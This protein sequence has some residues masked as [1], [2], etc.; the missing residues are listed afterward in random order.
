MKAM[1]LKL[2]LV[3]GLMKT[4]QSHVLVNPLPSSAAQVELEVS[5]LYNARPYPHEGTHTTGCFNQVEKYGD[6][7]VVPTRLRRIADELWGGQLPSDIRILDAGTGTGEDCVAFVQELSALFPTTGGGKPAWKVVCLDLSEAS[8]AAT[9]RRLE[10]WRVAER[11]TLVQGS[12]LDE[13][14]MQSLGTFDFILAEG[15]I[16]T[17]KTPVDGVHALARLR[18]SKTSVMSIFLY[19][20]HGRTGVTEVQRAFRILQDARGIT[21]VA[22][23]SASEIDLLRT[24][25][26]SLPFHSLFRAQ[27]R[28]EGG[29]GAQEFLPHDESDEELA[30]MFL[31]P[32]EHQYTAA[33]VRAMAGE[34]GVALISWLQPAL[35]YPGCAFGHLWKYGRDASDERLAGAMQGLTEGQWENLTET[36]W[37]AHMHSLS[38][39]FGDPDSFAWILVERESEYRRGGTNVEDGGWEFGFVPD[40]SDA[41][42]KKPIPVCNSCET[43]EAARDTLASLGCHHGA[44]TNNSNNDNN[45]NNN[46]TGSCP[47]DKARPLELILGAD[48]PL[49]A[50]SSRLG[51]L[52]HLHLN[53]LQVLAHADGTRNV[54]ELAVVVG[55]SEDEVT[56]SLQAIVDAAACTGFRHIIFTSVRDMRPHLQ[57]LHAEL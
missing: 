4:V 8:L 53:D 35:W 57:K 22:R 45:D 47:L 25:M 6:Q 46:S 43:L 34:V 49:I 14:L 30:D 37:G 15:S 3:A 9:A 7:L 42:Q 36:Y 12:F 24:Y 20:Q 2:G 31:H 51:F 13:T 33:D 41:I 23:Y 38:C 19:G 18:R 55:T 28:A 16:M 40:V 48:H 56:Q 26:H 39:L 29:T 32:C 5:V 44:S 11:P 50:E 17:L 27:R 10:H 52:A 54:S 21:G 1:S